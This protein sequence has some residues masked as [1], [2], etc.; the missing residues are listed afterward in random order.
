MPHQLGMVAQ[1][2]AGEDEKTK[3][4]ESEEKND[5]G[6]ALR[7]FWGHRRVSKEEETRS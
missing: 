3:K 2:T 5:E 1:K 6:I 4:I 7:S